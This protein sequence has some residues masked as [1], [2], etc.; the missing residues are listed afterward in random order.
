M[1]I[2]WVWGI[3][4]SMGIVRGRIS[5]G[6]A[7]L[8]EKKLDSINVVRLDADWCIALDFVC[9]NKEGFLKKS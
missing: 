5:G 4:L 8:W 9:N 3:D 2:S 6:V 1:M 7:I